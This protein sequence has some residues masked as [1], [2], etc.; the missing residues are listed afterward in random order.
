[1]TYLLRYRRTILRYRRPLIV[2]LH[3]LLVVLANYL[4]FLLRFDGDI[5]AYEYPLMTQMWPW[6]M[7]VRGLMFVPFHIYQGL[8]RYTGLWDLR[9]IITSVLLS[10]L[11]FYLLVH[12]WLG[13]VE[14]PR[15]V[16]AIDTLILICFLGGARLPWR[17]YREMHATRRQKRV[18]IYGAGDA[19]AMVVR[20][21]KGSADF[22]DC[23]P[24][25]FV[26]DDP[27]KLSR[28]IHGVPVLG[29]RADL[30]MIV[31]A[32]QPHEVLMA[33]PAVEPRV[34]R[35]I[36]TLLEPFKVQLKTLPSLT[37]IRH[38]KIPLSEIRELAVEDLLDRAPVGLDMAKV[39][40][41]MVGKRVLVTGAGGSIGSELCR[42]ISAYE[43][44]MLVLLDKGENALYSIDME[45]GQKFPAVQRAAVLTDIKHT[46]PLH[47]TFARYA[48]HVVFHAAAYKHVPMME[49]HPEEAILNNIVGT[50]RLAEMAVQH[51]VETFI[52]ISTDKAVNP[53]NIMGTTK[54]FGELYI[55]ART[56]ELRQGPTVFSAVRFGNVLGSNGSVVPLFLRQIAE[57]G[58]VT[59]THPEITRYFMTIPEAV[60]LVLQAA[61]LATGGE[62]F[63]LEMGEQVKLLDM[64]R[65]LIR[66]AG[67]VPGEE[68]PIT[69]VGLRPGEKLYEELV[70]QDETLEPSGVDRIFRVRPTRLPD[71]RYLSRKIEEL[72]RVAIAGRSDAVISLL[73]DVVST[74]HPIAPNT[75][76]SAKA[77]LKPLSLVLSPSVAH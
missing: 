56:H 52:F 49:C 4:A 33:L 2:G 75:T 10:S 7:V 62:I 16:F 51:R 9:N 27:S 32:E 40:R 20:D 1:M 25:G 17:L 11:G 55:Q 46:T 41:L 29:V 47:E 48:P 57:G 70:G 15:S 71:L 67:F 44:E 54:R 6:L 77:S 50:S 45:I 65:N 68:I 39:R 36:V 37:D 73:R 21:M 53:T 14:Y 26:D 66:I 24:I 18:L 22:Y 60:Q 8:W 12:W 34:V 5:P 31:A 61:T 42:Q 72:E 58:P 64:A 69:F 30:P 63:V 28:R 38:G 19:G 59:V 13:L 23:E 3:A 76:T 74:F 35:E 43:P